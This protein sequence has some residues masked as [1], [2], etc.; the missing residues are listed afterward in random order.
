MIV[1]VKDM[2]LYELTNHSE[3]RDSDRVLIR[4]IYRDFYGITDEPFDKVL[5]MSDLPSFETIR[6]VRQ[7]A[8]EHDPALRGS[9][10]VREYRAERQMEFYDFVTSN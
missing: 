4:Y 3:T 7:K 2:V 10:T 8:Q 1:K 5:M 9:K 6:R